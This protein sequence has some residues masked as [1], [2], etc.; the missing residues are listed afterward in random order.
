[1][2]PVFVLLTLVLPPTGEAEPYRAT[3]PSGVTVEVGPDSLVVHQRSVRYEAFRAIPD[4][5]KVGKPF[6]IRLATI[7]TISDGETDD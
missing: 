2:I 7:T 4:D 3:A 5:M 6:E 1:M